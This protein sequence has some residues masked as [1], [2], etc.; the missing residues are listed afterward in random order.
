L[1]CVQAPA[2]RVGIALL[3]LWIAAVALPV[4]AR[5]EA[6]WSRWS[7]LWEVTL[8]RQPDGAATCLWSTY[9]EPPPGHVRRLTFIVNR[10]GEVVLV[11]SDRRSPLHRTDADA[12]GL[13]ALGGRIYAIEVGTGIPLTG[14]PGGM[15]IGRLV[16]V[17]AAGFARAFGQHNNREI[18]LT[19]PSGWSWS[20]SLRGAAGAAEGVAS[21]MTE[22]SAQGGAR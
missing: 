8:D 5:A 2:F 11:V 12:R 10:R 18:R 21:C 4:A 22:T 15:L 6:V 20:M 1:D 16:G 13:L 17:D 14:L 3:A 9:D 7:G 19:L